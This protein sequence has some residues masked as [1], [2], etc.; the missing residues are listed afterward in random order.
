MKAEKVIH[1]RLTTFADLT[2]LIGGR[3]Y[4]VALPQ[5]PTYPCI[6]YRRVQSRRFEG[7]HDRGGYATATIQINVFASTY[8]EVKDIVEQVRLAL[9]RYGSVV[10]GTQIQG[11]T[12]YDIVIGTE[13]DSY[14]PTLNMFAHSLD[15][16][17]LH[18]E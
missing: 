8:D 6:A 11:V 10:T 2:S 14:E 12:V 7:L 17:V 3:V 16:E 13:A 18:A 15:F 5:S 4:P 9:D 1:Y